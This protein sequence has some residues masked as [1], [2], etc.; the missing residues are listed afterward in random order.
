MSATLR[1]RLVLLRGEEILSVRELALDQEWHLG[2]SSDSPLPLSERSISRQHVRVSC[3]AEG[4]HLEDLGSPNGTWVDEV[5]LKGSA[6]LRDGN[7]IRLGQST[8]PEPLLLR[9]EDP[10]SRLLDALVR[11]PGPP[12]IDV[13]A[14]STSAGKAGET[15]VDSPGPS[16]EEATSA[17]SAPGGPLV[18]GPLAPTDRGP[19]IDDVELTAPGSAE[20]PAGL[21]ALV[22]GLGLKATFGAALGFVAVFWL[23]WALKSTQKPWQTVRVEPQRIEAGVRVAIRGPEVEPSDSLKVFVDV[24]EAHVERMAAGEIAFTVPELPGSEAGTKVVALRVERGGIAVLRQNLQYETSPTVRSL[25]PSEAA[26]GDEVT[27]VG[28]G[29]A[30]EADRVQVR[31]GG[32]PAT[33]VAASPDRVRIKV[34]VVTRDR[35]A[36][37]P[38]ALAIEGLRGGGVVLKVHPREAPCY[39]LGFSAQAVAPGIFE[40]RHGLGS[41]LFLP[42]PGRASPPDGS[43]LPAPVRQAV[44]TVE[45]TFAKAAT[46]A[47]VHFEVREG[48]RGTSLLAVGLAPLP[49]EVTRFTPAVAAQV[50]ERAPALRQPELILYWDAVILNE[51]LNLFGKKQE[52]RLLPAAEAPGRILRRLYALNT[53]SGGQGCPTALEI[54]A[55]PQADRD[56]LGEAAFRVPA[57]FGDVAGVWEGSFENVGEEASRVT[58]E[59]RLDL[60]QTGTSL[61]G[62][63][64][65]FE[66][67]GP[68]IRWSPAPLEGLKGQVHLDAETRIELK[69]PPVAPYYLAQFSGTVADDVF[70][71]VFRTSRGQQGKFRLVPKAGQ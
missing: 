41:A 7:V 70:Q 14:G 37:A 22:R 12:P 6:L 48:G 61:E 45:A 31:V 16:G 56:A 47:T 55:L 52:P 69:L 27:I 40:L 13:G 8:N 54:A 33:V 35:T 17:F 28:L 34:P 4:V 23:L 42:G 43:E 24:R 71:G 26:V 50:K 15:P 49:R 2:R 25:E 67:R 1:P 51:L 62:R 46:D 39:A 60:Q 11:S 32:L 19:A 21:G 20:E 63:V 53:E 18:G 38:V 29:F 58:L 44:E 9:F 10:A 36:E 65:V 3:D 68:G 57:R 5:P 66:L 64:F 30:S 59:M